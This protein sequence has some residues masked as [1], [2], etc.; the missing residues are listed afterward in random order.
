M[1]ASDQP[2]VVVLIA[3]AS[4]ALGDILRYTKQC[5]HQLD[6]GIYERDLRVNQSMQKVNQDAYLFW[7]EIHLLA[8]LDDVDD[9]KH[10]T[11]CHSD[12]SLNYTRIYF[13]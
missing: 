6:K 5:Y 9:T 2:V 8:F 4:N 13:E 1:H 3:H 10:I 7:N 12:Q 11:S